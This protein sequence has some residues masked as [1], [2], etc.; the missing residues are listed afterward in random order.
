MIVLLLFALSLSTPA[1]PNLLIN[2][3]IFSQKIQTKCSQHLP[4]ESHHVEALNSLVC[5]EK[6]TDKNLRENLQ[7]TSLIHIFVVSGSHLLL[8][9]ELLGILRIP[10]YVRFF[11]MSFYSILIGWQ[12]PA[13]RA[14]LG[15]GLRRVFKHSRLFFPRDLSVLLTGA[16]ALI[17]FPAW[18]SS[19]S[20]LMSW[21]AAL[22][23]T[24]PDV[25]RIKSSWTRGFLTQFSIFFLMCAPL[26]GIGSLHPLSIVYN[27][28]LAPAISYILLPLSFLTVLCPDLVPA[29]DFVMELFAKSLPVLS[30]PISLTVRP[31]P[32][33][34][35]LWGWLLF[36]HLCFHFLRLHL[37]QGKD[38]R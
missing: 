35:L 30:E 18:W 19:W 34:P 14:L 31:P 2:T 12:A 26:W 36:W 11:F 22:A 13:V 17:L 9:D 28:F 20:F 37:W 10:F 15:L 24:T 16:A 38:L 7:K 6:I 4:K 1:S 23:L 32:T 8:L 29:F 3:S 27:L 25:L 33:I 21:C 5:G